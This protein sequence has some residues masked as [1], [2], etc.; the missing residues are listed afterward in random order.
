MGLLAEGRTLKEIYLWN[1]ITVW[2]PFLLCWGAE[3][4]SSTSSP[5]TIWE[6]GGER[7][8]A[9]LSFHRS[10]FMA[11]RFL[12]EKK[13]RTTHKKRRFRREREGIIPTQDIELIC[14]SLGKAGW[15]L[16]RLV[17]RFPDLLTVWFHDLL[18][19]WFPD[20]LTV[21]FPLSQTY[22]LYGT[23]TW[24]YGSQTYWLYGSQTYW[25][26]GSQT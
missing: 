13:G 1:L 10:G 15:F 9:K 19:L 16:V 21:W 5:F 20:L 2:K 4:T 6:G 23:L 24:P 14:S 25:L 18:T 3:S 22:W 26:Y 12:V 8:A 17:R 7:G 11:F